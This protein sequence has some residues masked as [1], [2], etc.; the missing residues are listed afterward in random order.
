MAGGVGE[1]DFAVDGLR[2][3]G[4]IDFDGEFGGFPAGILERE[5]EGGDGGGGAE[6]G[7]GAVGDVDGFDHGFFAPEE[8]EVDGG[9]GAGDPTAGEDEDVLPQV[10][11]AGLP[12]GLGGGAG[13]DVVDFGAGGPACGGGLAFEEEAAID[14]AGG[15]G[16]GDGDEA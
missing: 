16:R 13:E 9:G 10:E 7:F 6:G 12:A 14:G 15:A 2:E 11:L 8:Q 4:W 1:I 5:A 3:G